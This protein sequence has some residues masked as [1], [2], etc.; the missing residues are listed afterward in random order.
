MSEAEYYREVLVELLNKLAVTG[1]DQEDNQSRSRY[2]RRAE[3]ALERFEEEIRQLVSKGCGTQECWRLHFSAIQFRHQ[4]S[5]YRKS[6]TVA[7]LSTSAATASQLL[8]L[9]PFFFVLDGVFRDLHRLHQ[10]D[11]VSLGTVESCKLR[12]QSLFASLQLLEK[13]QPQKDSHQLRVCRAWVLQVQQYCEALPSARVAVEVPRLEA[14]NGEQVRSADVAVV[15][16]AVEAPADA[17]GSLAA[18]Q[19]SRSCVLM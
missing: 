10:V 19:H 3:K 14:L 17:I 5:A 13:A 2:V 9:L 8:H 4:L 1:K 16:R 11:D 18:P 6:S 15:L 12:I 7:P